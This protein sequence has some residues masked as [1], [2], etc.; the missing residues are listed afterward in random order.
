MH[1]KKEF[2]MST[3]SDICIVGAGIGGLTCAN[4]LIDAAASRK[5]R[6]RVF[7]LNPTVGGRIQSRK[8]DD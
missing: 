7:D 1:V 8:I 5:L 6:I 4:Q 2:R 3:Y